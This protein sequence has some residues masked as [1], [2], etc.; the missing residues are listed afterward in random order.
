[1]HAAAAFDVEGLDWRA[2]LGR[3]G[4]L[5]QRKKNALS[6]NGALNRRLFDADHLHS[7]GRLL[8]F[9]FGASWNNQE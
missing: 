8:W 2:D 7:Y 5:L 1:M 3:N 6:L 4:R 9:C